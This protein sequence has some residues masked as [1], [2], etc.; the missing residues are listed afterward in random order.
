MNTEERVF[1]FI[2]KQKLVWPSYAETVTLLDSVKTK[3]FKFNNY[4]IVA[5]HNPARIVSTSAK[6]DNKSIS[7]RKCFLCAENRPVEQ[8][9]F[10]I[11]GHY[12][13]LVNPFPILNNHLTIANRAFSTI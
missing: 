7:N 13:L 3:E 6:V 10:D 4:T 2:K 9:M 11:A 1:D 5:Q 8:L 12:S